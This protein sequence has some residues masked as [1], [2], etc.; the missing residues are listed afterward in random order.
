[1]TMNDA[2]RE[3]YLDGLRNA[4]ALEKQAIEIIERQVERMDRYPELMQ[5]LRQH[6]AE[7]RAQ[8][9]RLDRLLDQA[10]ESRSM[11]KDVAMSFM[12]NMTAMAHAP[13]DDEVLKNT[14]ADM[15]FEAY[16]IAAYTSLI[17]LA[18]EAGHAEAVG[19]LRRSL[20]EE[21]AMYEWLE[22]NVETITR[23][24]VSREADPSSATVR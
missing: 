9:E 14:F 1:M 16:E 23:A 5:R 17:A 18:E 6:L 10:G 7:T 2:A 4:H 15:G 11:L 22:R 21:R 24:Y 12:G 13:A 19:D 3:A 20:E 8:E